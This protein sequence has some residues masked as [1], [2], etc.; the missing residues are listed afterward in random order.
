MNGRRVIVGSSSRVTS[1]PTIDLLK[2]ILA[3]APDDDTKDAAIQLMLDASLALIENYCGRYFALDDYEE[4]FG[5]IDSR[6]PYLLLSAY[7]VESVA[8]VAQDM[9]L[10]GEPLLVDVIG[11]KLFPVSG[12]L[13]QLAPGACW[14]NEWAQ[15]ETVV[16]Y[17]GGYPPD[18]WPADL[19]D[20]LVRLFF[21]RWNLSGGTGSLEGGS[22]GGGT[23][24]IKSAT[25]DGMRLDYDVGASSYKGAADI[26]SELLPYAA[27][28]ARYR[29]LDRALWGV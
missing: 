24:E 28:L 10:E 29:A 19:V 7:P 18:A 3:I 15:T 5:P 4:R 2:S 27:V 6:Q 12:I 16:D 17:R 20:V 23:G 11:W 8:S 9:G 26:P 13:R 1:F 22:S 21:D 14:C 25:V